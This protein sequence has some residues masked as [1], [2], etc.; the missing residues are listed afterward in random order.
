[1]KVNVYVYPHGLWNKINNEV[2]A[3]ETENKNN[4]GRHLSQSIYLLSIIISVE[5]DSSFIHSSMY[6]NDPFSC[7]NQ[8]IM[9]EGF[10]NFDI[11]DSE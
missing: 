6:K 1:M 7:K 2:S 8:N 11:L 4:E 10:Q 3:F 5:V 9:N